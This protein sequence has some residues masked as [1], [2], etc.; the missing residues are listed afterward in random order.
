MHSG[1]NMLKVRIYGTEYMIRGQADAE[2]I[3]TVAEYVDKKMLEVNKTIDVDSSLKVAI[4][5][6]LNITD[7]LFCERAE[8]ERMKMELEEKIQRLNELLYRP[9]SMESSS[10]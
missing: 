6:T 1:K 4:L 7:E 3:K 5:A 2:Y 9:L 10:V 8:K